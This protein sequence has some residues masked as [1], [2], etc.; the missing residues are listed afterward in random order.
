MFLDVDNDVDSTVQNFIPGTTPLPIENC[1]EDHHLTG[2]SEEKKAEVT[3]YGDRKCVN[4]AEADLG[5]GTEEGATEN[6]VVIQWQ[7]CSRFA[8][9]ATTDCATKQEFETF[10]N[11]V[12]VSL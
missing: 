5:G 3:R 1:E 2:L 7:H 10:F 9:N 4:L 12:T 11:D 8:A 6:I